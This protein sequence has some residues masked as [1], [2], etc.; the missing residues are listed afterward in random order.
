MSG[1]LLSRCALRRVTNAGADRQQV[2]QRDGHICAATGANAG[3]VVTEVIPVGRQ[4]VSLDLAVSTRYLTVHSLG[5]VI[6]HQCSLMEHL[7]RRWRKGIFQ[8]HGTRY[9]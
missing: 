1:P 3:L 5:S 2:N 4:L 6:T 9:F 7:I 8:P